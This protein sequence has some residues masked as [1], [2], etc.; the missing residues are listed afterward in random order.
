MIQT[1]V[2]INTQSVEFISVAL[3]KAEKSII[4][5]KTGCIPRQT[6]K[7]VEPTNVE[8]RVAREAG[9]HWTRLL[10]VELSVA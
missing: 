8:M 4:R 5:A 6:G 1:S 7:A 3:A 9:R 2:A 10:D